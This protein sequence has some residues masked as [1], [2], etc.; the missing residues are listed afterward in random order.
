MG[1]QPN[2]LDLDPFSMNPDSKHCPAKTTS[3]KLFPFK[4]FKREELY[5]W[6]LTEIRIHP[7]FK[8]CD[9]DSI[10]QKVRWFWIP[11]KSRTY[12]TSLCLQIKQPGKTK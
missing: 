10:G 7:R 2:L 1:F 3:G 4:K 5:P 11:Y 12:R 6:S 8:N 9:P